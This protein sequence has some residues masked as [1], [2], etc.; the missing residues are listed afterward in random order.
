MLFFILKRKIATFFEECQF[1]ELKVYGLLYVLGCELCVSTFV[2]F[3][4]FVFQAQT[5]H[6]TSHNSQFTIHN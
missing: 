5:E 1:F 4:D 3:R 2:L 6:F